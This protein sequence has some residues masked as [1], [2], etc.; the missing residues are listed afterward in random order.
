M[1]YSILI[2]GKKNRE[3]YLISAIEQLD[4][5]GI[6]LTF[7]QNEDL[8]TYDLSPLKTADLTVNGN[9]VQTMTSLKNGD[10]LCINQV[11]KITFLALGEPTFTFPDPP[12][13][14]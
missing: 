10:R 5:N 8:K 4:I 2:K 7:T 11:Q 14:V 13:V 9:I 6:V 3:I 12:L 1:D